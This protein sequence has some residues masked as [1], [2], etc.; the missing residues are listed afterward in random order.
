MLLP[1]ETSM[2]VDWR[3]HEGEIAAALRRLRSELSAIEN[4]RPRFGGRRSLQ[5]PRS[6]YRASV[7]DSLECATEMIACATD[8]T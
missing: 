5:P 7:R 4:T 1:D 8:P 6:R 2:Q 3:S